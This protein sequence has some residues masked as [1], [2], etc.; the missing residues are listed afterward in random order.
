MWVI[1]DLAA[2]FGG[3]RAGQFGGGRA[4]VRADFA[5]GLSG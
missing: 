2:G 4:D 5:G 1:P 3:G